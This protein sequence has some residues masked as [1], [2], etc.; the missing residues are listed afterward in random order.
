MIRKARLLFPLFICLISQT[1][2]SQQQNTSALPVDTVKNMAAIR[3]VTNLLANDHSDPLFARLSVFGNPDC[4][5]CLELDAILKED[6][7]SFDE[8]DL[9]DNKLMMK[10]FDMVTRDNKDDNLNFSFPMVLYKG[11]LFYNIP[12]FKVFVEDLKRKLA[13]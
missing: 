11:E 6:H 1:V 7:I 4:H 5:R 9:R 13:E 3:L 2:F 8:Y 12:D 10:L